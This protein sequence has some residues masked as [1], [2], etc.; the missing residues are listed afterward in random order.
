MALSQF[1]TSFVAFKTVALA[2]SES[3]L[4][5]ESYFLVSKEFLDQKAKAFGYL[6]ASPACLT[7]LSEL[8]FCFKFREHSLRAYC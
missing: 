4:R 1:A 5:Q 8:C 2:S 6:L 7:H 3:S